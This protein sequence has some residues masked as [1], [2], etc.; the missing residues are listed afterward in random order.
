M[1]LRR[2]GMTAGGTLAKAV[3]MTGNVG[4][5]ELLVGGVASVEN[6]AD[7]TDLAPTVGRTDP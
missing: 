6:V 2:V 1:Q 5:G 3:G 4:D 7:G